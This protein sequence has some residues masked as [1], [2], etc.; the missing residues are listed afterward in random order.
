MSKPCV[1]LADDDTLVPE[2]HCQVV[3]SVAEP[4]PGTDD[5][6][7]SPMRQR[8]ILQPVAEGQTFEEIASMLSLSPKTVEYHKS[9]LMEQ[10]DLHATAEVTKYAPAHGLTPSSE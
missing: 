2:K 6:D 1:L 3:G 9:K 8:E 10:L 4:K 7:R 5:Q